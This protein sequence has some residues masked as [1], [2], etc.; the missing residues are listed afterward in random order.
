MY[1]FKNNKLPNQTNVGIKNSDFFR[2]VKL[3]NYLPTY[4]RQRSTWIFFRYL[5]KLHFLLNCIAAAANNIPPAR[6][7]SDTIL[8]TGA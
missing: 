6:A 3:S 8:G 7:A 5:T 4:A 1:Y 2:K